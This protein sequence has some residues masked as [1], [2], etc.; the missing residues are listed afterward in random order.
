MLGP[1]PDLVDVPQQVRGVFVHAHGAGAL[2]LILAIAARQEAHSEPAGTARREHVPDAVA[3][4]D[5]R[6]DVGAEP[7]GRGE[8][9]I[10]IRLGMPDIIPGDH[11]NLRGIDPQSVQVVFRGAHAAAGRDGPRDAGFGQILQQV[12][13]A[14]QWAYPPGETRIGLRVLALQGV[15]ER[16]S[17][18]DRRLA[19]QH[20]RKKTTAHP[21]L[22]MDAPH[23]ELYAGAMEG[24][25]P[26]LH[27]LIDAVD[28]RAIEVEEEAD[29]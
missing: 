9:E 4:D 23:R 26:G 15:E 24:L 21:Y 5:G 3:H 13:R 17:D 2:E 16:R 18:L 7:R 8:E 14:G 25:L 20:I 12:Y 27:V 19:Q 6:L 28:Q 22:S 29:V 1:A 10:G 11:R